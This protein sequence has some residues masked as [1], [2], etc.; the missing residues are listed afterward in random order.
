MHRKT[1][2]PIV[3]LGA[4][5]QLGSEMCRRLG[6]TAQPLSR[7]DLNITN[8][9]DVA[10][11]LHELQPETVINA[12]GYTQV[13]RAESDRIDCWKVNAEA[14]ETL[15]TVCNSLDCRLVQISSDYVFGADETRLTAYQEDDPI[16]PVNL[17][18]KSKAAGEEAAR[19][20][21]RHL[22]VRTCGLYGTPQSSLA[23]G[24][25]FAETMLHLA[26]KGQPLKVVADQRCTPSSVED[27]ATAIKLLLDLEQVG[28]FHITNSGDA[29]WYEFATEL[30]RQTRL[31]VELTPD[32]QRR[33]RLSR[34]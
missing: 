11:L 12:T 24:R 29:S 13:D 17:Y 22:I 33:V 2:R 18:G 10:K 28:T 4:T 9:V 32:L 16:H 21:P 1:E 23:L 34:R 15:A 3:V 6:T 27:V 30:F 31:A 20:C 5:G 8:R 26:S 7:A 14:V 19:S 25:N